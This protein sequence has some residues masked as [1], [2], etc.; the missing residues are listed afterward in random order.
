M[1][2][3]SFPFL[4]CPLS[5]SAGWIPGLAEEIIQQY[6][7]FRPPPPFDHT[8]PHTPLCSTQICSVN[9][10]FGYMCSFIHSSWSDRGGVRTGFHFLCY[11][12]HVMCRGEFILWNEHIS[13]NVFLCNNEIIFSQ[14]LQWNSKW[15]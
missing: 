15:S 11:L 12:E 10:R 13:V 7:I 1:C 5:F 6:P 14:L 2:G 8:N 4:S 9:Y 3:P